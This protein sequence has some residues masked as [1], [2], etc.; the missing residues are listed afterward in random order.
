MLELQ[1]KLEALE[2]HKDKSEGNLRVRLTHQLT[3]SETKHQAAK[4]SK[5]SIKI[6]LKQSEER[7]LMLTNENESLVIELS[8]KD[9]KSQKIL[10]EVQQE[11]YT[12]KKTL[13]T[14][15]YTQRE[16]EISLE[17]R[18]ARQTADQTTISTLKSQISTLNSKHQLTR[19]QLLA[20]LE[21]HTT[22]QKTL[23]TEKNQ[24]DLDVIAMRETINILKA[25]DEARAETGFQNQQH[26]IALENN[27]TEEV[28]K[29]KSH[30]KELNA[31]LAMDKTLLS[32]LSQREIGEEFKSC[33]KLDQMV[34]DPQDMIDLN[35]FGS[36]LGVGCGMDSGDEGSGEG[37]GE[38]WDRSREG[39]G[40][41]EGEGWDRSGE[42]EGSFKDTN[43]K[44][45]SM[46]YIGEDG[47]SNNVAEIDEIGWGTKK[48]TRSMQR[49]SVK[50]PKRVMGGTSTDKVGLLAQFLSSRPDIANW[51]S[52]GA[53]CMQR[54]QVKWTGWIK[55][56]QQNNIDAEQ[57]QQVFEV[58]S[59]LVD[60]D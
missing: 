3:L 57:Q 8:S 44:K 49:P 6:L 50:R 12:T 32:K 16:A 53:D 30:I 34:G 29:L 26:Y 4:D 9:R 20:D 39:E 7:V 24:L 11:L 51:E 17:N 45:G 59:L 35:N 43:T 54:K 15:Q 13:E 60:F 41:G 46:V 48:S 58:R 37:E 25:S 21:S 5:K 36:Q 27:C 10:T 38:E 2:T 47:K 18:G 31:R 42:G 56:T 52:W 19:Q 40:S 23:Q 33:F 28:S 1:D 22:T 55:S 14:L